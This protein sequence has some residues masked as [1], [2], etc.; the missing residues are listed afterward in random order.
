MHLNAAL[1]GLERAGDN[2]E[3][4]GIVGPISTDQ[5]HD[6]ARWILNETRRAGKRFA[7]QI[8]RTSPHLRMPVA[9][10]YTFY[11]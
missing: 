7:Q 3:H 8:W 9:N 10:G 2:L 4:R 11:D 6:L 1:A 5:A